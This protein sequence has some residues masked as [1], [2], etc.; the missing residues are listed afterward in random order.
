MKLS[1][2]LESDLNTFFNLEEFSE[3]HL[4][5][6]T[7]MNVIIDKEQ[8]KE[9]TS[10]LISNDGLYD[11][12]VL[13]FVKKADYGTKPVIGERITIDD[14]MFRCSDVNEEGMIYCIEL[15]AID[16]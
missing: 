14:D 10:K 7:L 11:V 5:N 2:L 9:R 13:L 1:A 3:E 15:V 16:S 8:L 12:D 6:G 4:I